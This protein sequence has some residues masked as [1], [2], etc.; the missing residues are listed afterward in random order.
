MKAVTWVNK[1]AMPYRRSR[2]NLP[3]FNYDNNYYYK[4]MPLSASLMMKWCTVGDLRKCI[5]CGVAFQVFMF[6]HSCF[7][8]LWNFVKN[9][10]SGTAECVAAP[11]FIKH[12]SLK[13]M[14]MELLNN[15]PFSTTQSRKKRWRNTE[16][17]D[18]ESAARWLSAYP[19]WE[20]SSKTSV[21]LPGAVVHL[22]RSPITL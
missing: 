19:A 7:F 14:A 6:I 1:L 16:A 21:I 4:H 2:N 15:R 11:L 20:F 8:H 18:T 5:A 22:C 10:T 3:S 17:R 9:K 12:R 13:N